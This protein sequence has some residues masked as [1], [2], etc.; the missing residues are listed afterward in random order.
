MKVDGQIPWNVTPFFE[1]SQIHCLTR[2]R[3]WKTFWATIWK[4]C[5]SIWFIGWVSPCNCEGSVPNS[6]IWKESFTW[7]VPRIRSARGGN[8][9]GW[10]IRPWGVGDDGRIGN[11]LEKTQCERGDVSQTRRISFPIA[12]GPIK[13]PGEDQELRTYTLIRQRPIQGEGHVDFLG[14]SEGSFPPPHDSLPVAGEAMHDFWSMS[15]SLNTAI[16]LNPES[17]FTRREK[18]HSLFHWS[19]LMSPELLIRIWMSSYK[20]ALMIIG[21]LMAL[22]TCLILGRFHT[23]CFTRWKSSWRMCLVR[24]ETNEKTAYIQA[25]SSVVRVIKSM[26][27]NAK[28]K[29]KQK[30]SEEKIHL[31]N[32]RKLRGICFIDPE[33]KEAIKN[34]RKK[35]ETSVAPAMPCQI[36]KN[37]WEWRIWQKQDKT[38]VCSGS[39]WIH[40]NAYGE[41]WSWK[42]RQQRQQWTR[43]GKIG[44]NFVVEPDESQK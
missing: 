7:I 3:P 2:K 25:R 35:L 40:Q 29:K 17:N 4:T 32:A 36:M 10:R 38:C 1:M 42:F 43:N 23:I 5:C 20:N 31:D 6:S 14:E 24:G 19:T 39:R 30:W 18:N 21:T 26:G 27:K 44:E 41:F 33:F 8:L 22:E 11:P 16:T 9:E 12:D 28:L 13:T 34:A 15:G 37:L